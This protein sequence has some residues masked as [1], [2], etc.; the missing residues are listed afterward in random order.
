MAGGESFE[1]VSAERG[2][3]G[4]RDLHAGRLRLRRV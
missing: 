3:G 4:N 2:R 1:H